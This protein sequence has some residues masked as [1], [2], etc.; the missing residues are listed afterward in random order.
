MRVR[1]AA[2][3]VW[4][5]SDGLDELVLLVGDLGVLGLE[6]GELGADGGP[7]AERLAGQVLTVL[8]EGQP[9][10]VLELGRLLLE[11]AG[12]DLDPLLAVA[13]SAMLRRIFWRF[14]SCFS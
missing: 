10:L 8:A 6:L 4:R 1:N 2:T 9:G 11:L 7:A 5:R 3:W 12:L 14:S 13:T